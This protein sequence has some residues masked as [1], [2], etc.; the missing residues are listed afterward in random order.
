MKNGK[1]W[2]VVY[3]GNTVDILTKTLRDWIDPSFLFKFFM[4]NKDDLETY[5]KVTNLDQAVYD[6]ITDAVSLSCL[7]LDIK[8]DSNLDNL[9]RPLENT[10]MSE[11]F[12]SKEK[13]KGRRVS[14]HA[15]WLRIYAIKLDS[16]IYLVTGGA[17]KLTHLMEDRA[18]TLEQL[19]KMEMVRNYLI[20]NSI[21]DTDGIKDYMSQS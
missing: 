14:G 2:A 1:L 7:I 11:M 4:D 19:N 12:L 10:R 6:T 9:F 8:P 17:I 20:D 15:S 18:H 3:D 16:G 13:A 21:F 5:F